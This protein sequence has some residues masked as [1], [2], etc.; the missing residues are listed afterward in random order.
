MKW[1]NVEAFGYDEKFSNDN[2]MSLQR[3]ERLKNANDR[4]NHHFMLPLT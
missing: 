4:V 1:D 3:S 2:S